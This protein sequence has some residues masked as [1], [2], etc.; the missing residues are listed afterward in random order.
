MSQS[1]THLYEIYLNYTFGLCYH[2]SNMY[3]K[4]NE[5]MLKVVIN[6]PSGVSQ[7]SQFVHEDQMHERSSH[8]IGLSGI[9]SNEF[10]RQK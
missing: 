10:H 5:I 6:R 3:F 1:M 8:C 2:F 9:K 7:Q 4:M